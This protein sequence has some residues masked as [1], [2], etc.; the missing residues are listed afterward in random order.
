MD[1]DPRANVVD[2]QDRSTPSTGENFTGESGDQHAR[3]GDDD[4][5]EA[6]GERPNPLKT[7]LPPD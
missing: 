1:R 7:P 6:D 2:D 4:E 3:Q 5:D